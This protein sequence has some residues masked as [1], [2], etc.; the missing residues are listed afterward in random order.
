M[1]LGVEPPARQRVNVSRSSSAARQA[2]TTR[3]APASATA[4]G[5][6]WTS[7]LGVFMPA[8]YRRRSGREEV[9]YAEDREVFRIG[10]DEAG[11]AGG[12]IRRRVHRVD[13]ALAAEAVAGVPV[14]K[15]ADGDGVRINVVHAVG[16]PPDGCLRPRI[17][18]S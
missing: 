8:V 9:E 13:D 16:E 7:I 11:D 6:G 1:A 18:D 17:I 3:S 12:V 5:V 14:E 10:G 2:V 15:P 4:A